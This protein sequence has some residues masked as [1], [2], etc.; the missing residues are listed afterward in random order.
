M[1]G[2]FYKGTAPTGAPEIPGAIQARR[3]F[4]KPIRHSV[5]AH[6]PCF[7][8]GRY[9]GLLSRG[10]SLECGYF[11]AAPA[12]MIRSFLASTVTPGI[13]TS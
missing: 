4:G 13:A 7:E 5:Y 12:G 6:M 9:E 3:L 8:H 2:A 1:R 11:G 10:L